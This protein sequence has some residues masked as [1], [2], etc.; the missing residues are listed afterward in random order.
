[1]AISLQLLMQRH[2]QRWHIASRSGVVQRWVARGEPRG[3]QSDAVVPALPALRQAVQ[4]LPL[5]NGEREIAMLLGDKL[6]SRAIADKLTLSVRT[7]EGSD[8]PDSRQARRLD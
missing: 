2:T 8:R 4:P 7:V 6:T 5:S 3:C 1:L